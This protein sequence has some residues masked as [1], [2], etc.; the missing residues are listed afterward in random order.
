MIIAIAANNRQQEA[1]QRK[2]F[3]ETVEIRWVNT[4]EELY[5][6][7]EADVLLD[8][9]F[10]GAII[11]K[12]GKPLLIHSPTNTLAVLNASETIVRF[13]AWNSFLERSV[14][15]IAVSHST[16]S[17]WLKTLMEH[18]GWKYQLVKDEPGLIAPRVISMVINEAYYALEQEVSSKADIDTAMKLGTNYPYGPFEWGEI[19]GLQNIRK[20]LIKLSETDLRY[21]PSGLLSAIE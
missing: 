9:L 13:C 3:K 19:I 5:K 15:E 18:L 1:L 4:S 11:P 6:V 8:C 16:E 17:L 12:C 7:Q 10:E 20:L 21:T 14:W 2:G